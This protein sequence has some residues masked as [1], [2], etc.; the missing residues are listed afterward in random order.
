MTKERLEAYQSMREE[1]E[2]LQ[3]RLGNLAND[4]DLMMTDTV[5]DYSSGRGIPKRVAGL[6]QERYWKRKQLYEE[7]AK[8]LKEDCELIEKWVEQIQDS[9]TRRIFRMVYVD[10]MSQTDVGNKLHLERS[11]ISK[12]I[13]KHL[14][15]ES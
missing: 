8:S 15:H 12:R 6:D 1:I 5:L 9:I 10:G 13:S 11:S 3:D 4:E 2:E 7:R 14:R